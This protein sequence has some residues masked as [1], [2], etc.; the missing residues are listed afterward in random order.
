[1]KTHFNFAQKRQHETAFDRLSKKAE[2]S[3][4]EKVERFNKQLEV[5]F[6]L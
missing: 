1:M 2:I 4:R 3:H 6:W 5:L